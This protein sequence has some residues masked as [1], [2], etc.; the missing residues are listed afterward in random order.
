MTRL[1]DCYAARK[2]KLSLSSNS[3]SDPAQATGSSQHAAE[4]G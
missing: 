2:R 1:L 3:E 4:G